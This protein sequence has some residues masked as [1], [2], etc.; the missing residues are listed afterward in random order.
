MYKTAVFLHI[1]AGA[2]WVG[3]SVLV[4]GVLQSTL[5]RHGQTAAAELHERL[6]WA[7][8]AIYMPAPLVVLATGIG[9]VVVNDAW[10]FS[11]FWVYGALALYL[12]TAILGGGVLTR[13]DKKLQ[14]AHAEGATETSEFGDLMRRYVSV[15]SLDVVLLTALV[16]LMA[17]KPG[18]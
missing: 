8:K 2:A 11:Q 18:A 6:G 15:G 4:L 3:A 14:A 12:M 10:R 17:F 5:K 13:M 7:D 9:L 1:L 16:F